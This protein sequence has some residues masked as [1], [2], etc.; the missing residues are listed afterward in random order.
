MILIVKFATVCEDSVPHNGVRLFVQ[1]YG[2]F[3]A[4]ARAAHDCRQ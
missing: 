3:N 1:N 4:N 2:I